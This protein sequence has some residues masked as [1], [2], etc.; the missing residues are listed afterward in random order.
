MPDPR[1]GAR[2][3]R[4][5]LLVHLKKKFHAVF[6]KKSCQ[7]TFS[8]PQ[9][10]PFCQHCQISLCNHGKNGTVSLTC[11]I[12]YWQS[13]CINRNYF[14]QKVTTP[15]TNT[16]LH[17]K[18]LLRRMHQKIEMIHMYVEQFSSAT[19]K[20]QDRVDPGPLASSLSWWWTCNF[21]RSFSEHTCLRIILYTPLFS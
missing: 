2:D 8:Q 3:L 19:N 18:F 15:Q 12:P 14:R 11:T 7:I 4:S 16:Y 6:G 1:G 9:C 5:L 21:A 17:H 13:Y 20:Q 10:K